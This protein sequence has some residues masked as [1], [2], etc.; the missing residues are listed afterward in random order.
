[1]HYHQCFNRA[2][3]KRDGEL[4]CKIHDPIVVQARNDKRVAKWA[5]KCDAT[6]ARWEKE[7]R[8]KVRAE[9]CVA[10]CDWMTNDEVKKMATISRTGLVSLLYK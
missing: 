5:A 4:F 10:A 2:T 1:M 9:L 7:A 8:E 6:R 3:V